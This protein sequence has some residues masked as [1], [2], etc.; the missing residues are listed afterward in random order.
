MKMV[1]GLLVL[2]VAGLALILSLPFLI[3]LSKYQDQYKPLI[4]EALKEFGG[5]SVR[6]VYDSCFAGAVGAL[7]LAMGMPAQYWEEL[8]GLDVSQND[9]ALSIRSDIHRRRHAAECQRARQQTRPVPH[10]HLFQRLHS[11]ASSPLLLLQSE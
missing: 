10:Q 6:K 3:D 9:E 1:I 8:R 4:E 2:A 7:K 5:G 11:A